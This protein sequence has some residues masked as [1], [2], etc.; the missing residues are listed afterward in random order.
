MNASNWK[1]LTVS[2]VALLVVIGWFARLPIV[3]WLKRREQVALPD[4]V[5]ESISAESTPSQE[6]TA[7]HSEIGSVSVLNAA[8][9]PPQYTQSLPQADTSSQRMPALNRKSLGRLLGIAA[10]VLMLFS[11]YSFRWERGQPWVLPTDG[12]NFMALGAVTLGASLWLLRPQVELFRVAKNQIRATP[13]RWGYVLFGVVAIL[14]MAEA[15]GRWLLKEFQLSQHIQAVFFVGGTA[16]V[17]FGLGGFE[18]V[19]LRGLFKRSSLLLWVIILV[20]FVLRT[21]QLAESVHIMIDELHFYDGVV[22]LWQ[23]PNLPLLQ[24]IDGLAALPH[25]F[26]Y[27]EQWTVALFGSDFFGIRFASALFGTLTIVAVYF[28]GCAISDRKTGLLAAALLAVF[29]PHMH[30]SRLAMINIADPLFGTLAI[31]FLV[32]AL[33]HNTQRNYVL[34]GLFLG[35]SSYFYEGGRL[36]FLAL[37]IVWL[38]FMLVFYRPWAHRRG[39]VVMGIMAL[40]MLTPYYYNAFSH[41]EGL[42]PRLTE[43][44]RLGYLIRDLGE[45]PADEVLLRHY[46]EALRP[47]IFHTIYSPDSSQFYYGG[48]TP[49]LPWYVVPFYLLGLF[50]ML[51]RARH[52]GVLLWLWVVLGL[53]GISLVV[54]TDWTVRF[55]ALFPMMMVAVAIGLRYPF[56]MLLSHQ[57]SRRSLTILVILLV[58][59][60]GVAQ[61]SHYFGEHLTIYNLQIRQTMRDFYDVFDRA[62]QFSGIRRLIYIT[63]DGV[64]NPVL[65]TSRVFRPVDMTYEIWSRSGDFLEQLNN[66]PRD[67]AYA[68]ALVPGD[69]E[70]RDAVQAVFPL[71]LG[72]WS[73]YDSVPLER[74]Y[75]LYLYQPANR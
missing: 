34:A 12:L 43:Q 65:D 41:S 53:L 16:L 60:I 71:T 42:T 69:T 19:N 32:N 45:M 14:L 25:F 10:I 59:G 63:D 1:R 24:H 64:F 58:V 46:E 22:H 52:I 3:R 74:Q 5:E 47:A 4:T 73:A 31:A 48:Y 67:G 37:F 29:P 36:L 55:I 66:L 33:R 21:W 7:P 40:V 23:D 75:A 28:L 8:A 70:T 15:N 68:F 56:E 57:L 49:I 13:I 50:Y 17:A 35:I 27:V 54:S 61:L 44:G 39:L 18:G 30:F 20:G 38:P 51:F 62:S 72:P 2:G 11:G 9:D 26:P 6:I